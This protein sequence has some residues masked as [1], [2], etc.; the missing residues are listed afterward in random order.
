[1]TLA[2]SAT[3]YGNLKWMKTRISEKYETI[4]S[5][6]SLQWVGQNG[7]NPLDLQFITKSKTGDTSYI[8]FNAEVVMNG[9]TSGKSYGVHLALVPHHTQYNAIAGT[10]DFQTPLNSGKYSFSV[11]VN[12]FN[13]YN[14]D[15]TKT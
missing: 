3:P 4:P 10:Y 2:K 1:M 6:N 13:I 14:K 12:G 15:L 11:S 9:L 8:K 5:D 7:D